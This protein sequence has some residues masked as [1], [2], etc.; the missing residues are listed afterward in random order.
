M[1]FFASPKTLQQPDTHKVEICTNCGNTTLRQLHYSNNL[2]RNKLSAFDTDV[3]LSG[4][5]SP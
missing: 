3:S 4:N 2:S 5:V 1:R